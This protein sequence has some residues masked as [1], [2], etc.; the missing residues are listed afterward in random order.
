[1]S[2]RRA[3]PI[4]QAQRSIADLTVKSVKATQKL[5]RWYEELGL[6]ETDQQY[7]FQISGTAATLPA[8]TTLAITFDFPFHFAPAQRDSDLETP[9]MTYGGVCDAFVMLSAHVVQWTQDEDTG[10]YTAALVAVGCQAAV[11]DLDFTGAIHMTFQGY[12]APDDTDTADI[13]T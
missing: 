8:F 9:Q 3:R 7:Q 4:H 6:A 10:A 5:Q 11:E 2:S 12:S 1:V 13:E